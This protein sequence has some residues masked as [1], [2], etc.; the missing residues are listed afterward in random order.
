V[1]EDRTGTFVAVQVDADEDCLATIAH[2]S[3]RRAMLELE[4][5]RRAGQSRTFV[6]AHSMSQGMR[7]LCSSYGVE[8]FAVKSELVRAWDAHRRS[9]GPVG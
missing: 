3:M 5:G 7:E 9:E 2:A 4:L 1:L 8:C 6:V